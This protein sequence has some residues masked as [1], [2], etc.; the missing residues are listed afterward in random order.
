MC[1]SCTTRS[2]AHPCSDAFSRRASSS[3]RLSHASR[4]WVWVW[5]GVRGRGRGKG[6]AGVMVRVRVRGGVRVRA[7]ARARVEQAAPVPRPRRLLLRQP[8]RVSRAGCGRAR[9]SRAG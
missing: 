6:K 9:W 7:R 2:V 8:P 4:V 1:F 3:V 5:V